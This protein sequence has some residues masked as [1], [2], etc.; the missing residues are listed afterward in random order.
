MDTKATDTKAPRIMR[1]D[2]KA[3]DTG[4]WRQVSLTAETHFMVSIFEV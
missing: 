3:T 2:T 4:L 1:M